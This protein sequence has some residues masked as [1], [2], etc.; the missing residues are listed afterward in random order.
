MISAEITGF[1]LENG[2]FVFPR[3]LS[4]SGP[5]NA[6][7]KPFEFL[8]PF[9]SGAPG[10]PQAPLWGKRGGNPLI[11]MNLMEFHQKSTKMGGFHLFACISTP[12]HLE[13]TRFTPLGVGIR[14]PCKGSLGGP[15]GVPGD[16]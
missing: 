8:S 10:A 3:P 12:K 15:E 5:P 4:G 11:S 16:P 9:R 1:P 13:V 6:A 2:I 7:P 14:L